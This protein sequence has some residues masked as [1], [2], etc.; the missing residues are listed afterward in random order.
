MA[1]PPPAI[2]PAA[3]HGIHQTL[4]KLVAATEQAGV[5][6]L[7]AAIVSARGKPTSIK[8]IMEIGQSMHFALRPA[9]THSAYQAWAKNQKDHLEKV[10][11]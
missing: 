7:V 4:E 11:D 5:A 3:I 6:T 2:S 1:I 8:E 9:P 10:W